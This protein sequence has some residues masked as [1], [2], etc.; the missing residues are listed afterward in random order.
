MDYVSWTLCPYLYELHW[1]TFFLGPLDRYEIEAEEVADAGAAVVE[2]AHFRE[3]RLAEDSAKGAPTDTGCFNWPPWP[4]DLDLLRDL[5]D[6]CQIF[7][8]VLER[9]HYG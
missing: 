3:M 5:N 9:G 7:D 8:A 2:W 1:V 4:G 6:Y